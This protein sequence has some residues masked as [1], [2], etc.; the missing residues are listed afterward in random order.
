MPRRPEWSSLAQ[1]SSA[2]FSSDAALS[3]DPLVDVA[4]RHPSAASR[5]IRT[6]MAFSGIGNFAVCFITVVF[7]VEFWGRCS[8]CNR[9]L[10]WWLAVHTLLQ[11]LQ[12]PARAVFFS[13]LQTVAN[14]DANNGVVLEA[15]V[16]SFTGSVAWKLT[17]KL[18]LATYG[19]LVLGCTWL[20]N[21]GECP[22]TVFWMV[23]AVMGQAAVRALVGA[24]CFRGLL[25]IT[26]GHSQ[27]EASLVVPATQ[28]QIIDLPV[29]P[30]SHDLLDESSRS[31][32][33]CL[34]DYDVHDMLRRLPC[35]HYFHQKCCDKWLQRSNC[36]PLC[37]MVVDAPAQSTSS[38]DCS[39]SFL[40]RARVALRHRVGR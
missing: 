36:C 31:C 12:I 3:D 19:W 6:L 33:V 7:L 37:R 40:A 23:V 10:R 13:K 27:P 9:P 28:Q 17:K 39:T 4:R 26:W 21:A 24:I 20:V 29:V 2:F 18:S 22:A 11:T 8:E 5:F 1:A 35:E 32:A 16:A 15:C 25:P 34:L 30:F 38:V 14:I